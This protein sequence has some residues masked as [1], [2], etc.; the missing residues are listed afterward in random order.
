MT[1]FDGST[2][3]L[4]VS[5]D[6]PLPEN[7][8]PAL[9]D[10]SGTSAL[11]LLMQ[12]VDERE[13]G[14]VELFPLDLPVK[15]VRLMCLPDFSFDEWT[16]WQKKSIPL[17]KRK[18]PSAMDINQRTLYMLALTNTA[19]HLEFQDSA[20][21]WRPILSPSG[22]VM[23]FGS[24]AMRDK[25]GAMTS[26]SLIE[27]LFGRDALIIRAGTRLIN[28]AGYGDEDAE[29]EELEAAADPLV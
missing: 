16:E 8:T 14:Q 22:D 13:A 3:N 10:L 17:A 21:E 2:G 1:T 28:V 29:A 23:E 27:K 25:F 5:A 9:V 26:A 15:G 20:G 24:Q 12:A 19:Q 11:D 7:S 4:P 6:R 18:R